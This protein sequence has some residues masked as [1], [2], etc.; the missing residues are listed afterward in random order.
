MAG[1]TAMAAAAALAAAQTLQGVDCEALLAK[2]LVVAVA[3]WLWVLAV[4][5]QE[6]HLQVVYLLLPVLH[7]LQRQG[8]P[9]DGRS[10]C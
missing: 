5:A 3:V 9:Q 7:L 4:L 6:Q 8:L 2:A 10:L 1:M